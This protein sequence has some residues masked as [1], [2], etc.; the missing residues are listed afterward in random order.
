MS[1]TEKWLKPSVLADLRRVDAGWLALRQPQEP[2]KK[3]I[4]Q[5]TTRLPKVQFDVAIAGGTLGI[6]LGAALVKQGFRVALIERGVLRGRAQEWN[7]SR[8]DL[9]IFVELELL[10]PAEL[11]RAMV[12][13]CKR[14]AI[15]FP[16]AQP[17]WVEGVLDIGIEPIYLLAVLKE[18]FLL[19]G[20]QLFENTP[21]V[22]ATIHPNGVQVGG[23]TCRLLV[24]AMG[25]VSPITQQ[26]RNGQKPEGI[27][28]VVGSCAQGFVA[29]DE[30]D[31]IASF[32]PII[33]QCQYLWE[34]FPAKDGRTTYLFTYVD[35]DRERPSL[36]ALFEDY[37]QLLPDYQGTALEALQIERSLFGLFPAFQSGGIGSRFERILA[38]GDSSGSQSPL[39]FGGFGAMV[40]HLKRLTF[41][42]RESLWW[43]CLE[44]IDLDRLQP[45]QPNLAVT[46]LF[47]KTMCVE[48][49]Q[50]ID[51]EQVNRLLSAV[52]IQMESL[53][54]E[55][56]RP[57][58]QDVVQFPALTKTLLRL[59]IAEPSLV[60]GIVAQVG[61]WALLD[62]SR[63]Y[64]SLGNYS[65]LYRLFQN[66]HQFFTNLPAPWCYR[67]KRWL[68][69]WE[70]G[71]GSDLKEIDH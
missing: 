13:H 9:D 16:G 39:S 33:N 1:L 26:A 4:V 58:L 63:H 20:G 27:C 23:I 47:Q 14:S 3:V 48:V 60:A 29:N 35:T 34:A 61:P 41:G 44:S 71:S 42:I 59:A 68:D 12:T 18:K 7:I 54:P 6:L 46:W 38:V 15:R 64:L 10:T 50:K 69:A 5:R 53:G 17:I 52:F 67:M 22:G 21:F 65:G 45:Y 36:E 32:T 30:A 49:H 11:E 66:Q 40:R 43:D 19:Y 56:L 24:D 2:P 55:V 70:Y 57:F 51:P 31:L 37:L 8:S 28:L 25:H 62:W